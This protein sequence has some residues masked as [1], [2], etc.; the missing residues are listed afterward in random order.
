MTRRHSC[1]V[2]AR[3]YELDSFGHVNYAV[4]LNYFEYARYRA[5][6][7]GGFS[8]ERLSER[9]EAVHVVHVEVDY[10]NELRLGEEVVIDTELVGVRRTSMNIRQVARHPENPDYV[11]AE[12]LVVI[13]WIGP[14]GRPMRVPNDVLAALGA[15][16][17][18]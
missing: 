17:A 4:Y 3:S 18:S 7:D 12:G 5:F 15:P 6:A 10:R 16:V 13:V 8:A 14:D 11:Y 1:P 2:D 9:G